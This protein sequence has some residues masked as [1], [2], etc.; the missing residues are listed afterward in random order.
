[1][2][3]SIQQHAKIKEKYMIQKLLQQLNF[4]DKE[5][6]VYLA[7]L[8]KGKVSPSE[9]S[10]VTGIQR[11][12]VYSISKELIKKGVITEDLGS[13]SRYLVSS[14]TKNLEDLV[15]KEEEQLE[16]KKRIISKAM[17]EL[18][19]LS[20]SSKYSIPKITFID[21]KGLNNYLKKQ[22]KTWI[23]SASEYDNIWWGFQDHTLVEHYEEWINWFWNTAVPKDQS[24]R[25]LGNKAP[26][27]TKMKKKDYKR[28]NIKFWKDADKFTATTWIVGDYI[29]MV[30]TNQKPHFLVEIHDTTLA[31]NMREVFKGLWG[32]IK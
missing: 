20:K 25:L 11:T 23:K 1:M 18:K 8:Q 26:I 16:E 6:R 27:E 15:K 10:K 30:T 7:V 31:H 13:A 32:K 9:V 14:P 12:T 19:S 24:L 2:L 22:T 4:T 21:E 5:I 3:T 28:R 29:V 17:K